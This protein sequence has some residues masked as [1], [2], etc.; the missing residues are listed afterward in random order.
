MANKT[1]NYVCKRHGEI[2][3]NVM[4]F[5][6]NG[7]LLNTVCF[8]CYAE[9]LKENIGSVEEKPSVVS[10]VKVKDKK[11]IAGYVEELKKKGF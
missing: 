11:R 5:H 1:K 9:F 7:E 2:G 8:L 4:Q 3:D 6:L 10:L